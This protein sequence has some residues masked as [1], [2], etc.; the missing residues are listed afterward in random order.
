ME[1]V[2]EALPPDP[3]APSIQVA[4]L[5]DK[6][7]IE[8]RKTEAAAVRPKSPRTAEPPV[9]RQINSPAKLAP[10]PLASYGQSRTQKSSG[11]KEKRAAPQQ[12]ERLAEAVAVEPIRETPGFIAFPTRQLLAT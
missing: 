9:I 6:P 2:P 8:T 10:G 3:V 7:N 11:M 4:R 5:G 12:V 1:S